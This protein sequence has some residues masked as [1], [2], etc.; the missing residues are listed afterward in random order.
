MSSIART[1]ARKLGLWRRQ[2][3]QLRS[4]TVI[5]LW[6]Y[7]GSTKPGCNRGAGKTET[8]GRIAAR[9]TKEQRQKLFERLKA[10]FRPHASRRAA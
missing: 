9:R 4:G 2:G 7:Q 5:P 10:M 3:K 1:R 6:A 8:Y